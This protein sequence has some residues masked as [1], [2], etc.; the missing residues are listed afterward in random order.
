MRG[1]S[2]ESDPGRLIPSPRLRLLLRTKKEPGKPGSFLLHASGLCAQLLLEFELLFEDE[3]EDE[4]E[5]L[6][7]EE[8][9]DELLLELELLFD[10]EFEDEFEEELLLELELPFDEEFEDEFDEELLLEFELPFDRFPLP[11]PLPCA[12]MVMARNSVL[13]AG[14]A[15]AALAKNAA[16]GL[17][18]PASAN[19]G[20]SKEPV[21]TAVAAR[22][23]VS[24]FM[25][26]LRF[27]W[28]RTI[29]IP[30]T[31]TGQRAFYSFMRKL[32]CRFQCPP[33][34]RY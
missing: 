22:I 32:I 21:A 13:T 31:P 9:D 27:A 29:A 30:T 24:F 15:F 2:A 7:E 1:Q 6:F 17:F 19:A 10:E 34:R 33:Q 25:A 28:N 14:A 16:T 8:F 4:F 18:R 23:A 12:A 20:V 26:V 11:F 3:L 5:L